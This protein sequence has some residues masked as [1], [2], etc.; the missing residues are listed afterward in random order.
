MRIPDKSDNKFLSSKKQP[1][2]PSWFPL[3]ILSFLSWPHPDNRTSEV[4]DEA[5][6]QSHH[7]SRQA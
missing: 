7:S 4:S 6:R 5:A 1:R 3:S 2:Q